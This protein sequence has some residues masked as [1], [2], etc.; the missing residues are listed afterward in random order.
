MNT[1]KLILLLAALSLVLAAC[2]GA[3]NESPTPELSPDFSDFV[4]VASATG[5]V[6][7]AQW[8]TVSIQ[9][10]GIVQ[11]MI[12]SENDTVKAGDVL[13]TLGGGE[14]YA[15]AVTAVQLELISAQQAL[16]TLQETATLT[17]AQTAQM[18]ADAR[19]AVRDAQQRVNN[20]NFGSK[21]TDIDQAFANLV[22][23]EDRLDK[24]RDNFEPYENKAEDNLVRAALLSA[25]AQAQSNYDAA[26][27]LYNNLTGAANDID[28]SQAEADLAYAQALLVKLENDYADQQ[29][30]PDPDTL[31]LAQAR[32]ENAIAQVAA[33]QAALD[34]LSLTAPFDGT[35][36]IIYVRQSEWVNPGQPILL[37]GDLQNL[38]IETTDL[39]EIDVARISVGNRA[40]I[41]FDALPDSAVE[42][43]V[44]RIGT[45]AASGSS[46]NYTVIIEMDE[47][48][49]GLLWDMTAFI[50]I[51]VNE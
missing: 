35:V 28:L 43:T 6:V 5:K 36:S 16:E 48:P 14:Q 22:L 9:S 11:E 44:V 7:P 2:G 20:L 31:A 18:V 51:E 37:I 12:V 4:P 15:A 33:A 32:L 38:Q 24:A 50:D 34:D 27:R 39:N 26:Q 29:D 10:A 1:K 30:G 8:A 42:G 45:K 13:L 40:T 49:A 17:A 21:Q 46:V 19:D 3:A 41:T 25:L 23:A 47:I